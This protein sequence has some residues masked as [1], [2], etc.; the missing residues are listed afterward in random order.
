MDEFEIYRDAYPEERF[1]AV[2]DEIRRAERV[3]RARE[4]TELRRLERNAALRAR[5]ARWFRR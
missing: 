4:A 2:R 1:A 3:L 5:F